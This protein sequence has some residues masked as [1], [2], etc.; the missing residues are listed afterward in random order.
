VP[1]SE[2]NHIPKCFLKLSYH[3]RQLGEVLDHGIRPWITRTTDAAPMVEP[4]RT[5]AHRLRTG[6]VDIQPV[7]NEHRLR[8]RH[9]DQRQSVPED[10]RIRLLITKLATQHD[11]R[12]VRREPQGSDLVMLVPSLGVADQAEAMD[13]RK[14]SEGFLHTSKESKRFIP[15]VVDTAGFLERLRAYQPLLLKDEPQAAH[16]PRLL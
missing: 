6:D 5:H 11:V 14:L 9:V 4:H 1:S 12:K 3:P 13:R 10:A 2:S 15:T 7:A 16:G 8:R